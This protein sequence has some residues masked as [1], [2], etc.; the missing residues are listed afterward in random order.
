M[1]TRT[2]VYIRVSTTGQNEGG[3]RREI[4]RWLKGNGVEDVEWYVDKQTGDNLDRP[5]FKR[6]QADVFNGEIQMIVVWKLDR[7]S[8]SLRDGIDTLCDWCD[9]GLRL[10]SV[11]QQLDFNGAVG[12]LIASVLFAV[13]EMEQETRRE[14]QRAGIEA[15][16]E[17]GVYKG[18]KRG[19]TKA[20]PRRARALRDRGLTLEEIAKAMGVSRM[21]VH[22]YL[23]GER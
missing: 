1:P 10:V 21:T 4:N 23:K 13:A 2:A 11:T 3:Q 19:S 20:N 12:K 22:R 6:L 18:R 5:D 17:R 7:L 16:R 14:R 8:R 9:R 15:A